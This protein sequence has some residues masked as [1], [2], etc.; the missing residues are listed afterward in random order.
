MESAENKTPKSNAADS[1]KDESRLQSSTR[2]NTSETNKSTSESDREDENSAT[3]ADNDGTRWL[4]LD[5]NTIYRLNMMRSSSS[6]II[7]GVVCSPV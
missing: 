1:G 6:S 2:S 7:T 4:F 5:I 3:D